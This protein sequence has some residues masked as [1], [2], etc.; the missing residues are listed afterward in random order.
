MKRVVVLR[1]A[2]KLIG[3]ARR[4]GKPL[5]RAMQKYLITR[6][7]VQH[8]YVLATHKRVVSALIGKQFRFNLNSLIA[9]LDVCVYNR[10][11]TIALV[12]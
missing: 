12:T 6:C 3:K 10:F 2:T 7:D 5:G 9:A 1:F 4:L 8:I 11:V